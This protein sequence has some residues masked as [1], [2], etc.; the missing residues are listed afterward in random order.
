MPRSKARCRFTQRLVPFEVPAICEVMGVS[1]LIPAPDR[2]PQIVSRPVWRRHWKARTGR[3]DAHNQR[4]FSSPR[5]GVWFCR[6]KSLSDIAPWWSAS[7]RLQAASCSSGWIAIAFRCRKSPHGGCHALSQRR[8]S[9]EDRRLSLEDASRAVPSTRRP[10]ALCNLSYLA[11]SR[12]LRVTY[13]FE[14]FMSFKP[15]DL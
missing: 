14:Q 9:D 7:C 3:R 2:R 12:I 8:F 6:D 15:P 13:R 11:K 1:G 10:L 4:R 5:V